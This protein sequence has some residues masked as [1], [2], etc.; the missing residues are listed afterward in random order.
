MTYRERT[1]AVPG[2]V[3]WERRVGAEPERW[4]ILPDGCVDLLWDGRRLV[5]A[6]PDTTA[7]WHESAPAT[8][9][10][11]LRLAGGLGPALLGVRAAEVRDQSP[12]LDGVWSSAAA[13]A[14]A[15]RV[16]ADPPAALAAWAVE[17]AA[18]SPVDPLGPDVL[19]MAARGVP[20]AAM[21]DQL[22]M[23]PRHLHR[24]C[25]ALFGYGPRRLTRVLRLGR[26][27]AAARAGDPLA[28]VAA[29]CGYVDQAHLSREV[30]A[31]AGTT[32][33]GLVGELPAGLGGELPA[34]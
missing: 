21:A 4:R 26:A 28:R 17:R 11:A 3:L 10:V 12:D 30:R 22:A 34:G 7:R 32:P 13:R 18:A 33:A 24:H 6:G 15:E 20:V 23:S 8:S 29:D 19:A 31:L 2:A 9:Y 1:L 16:A 5:V 27:V 14:L 25:L